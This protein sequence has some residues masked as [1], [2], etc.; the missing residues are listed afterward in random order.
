MI[1][2]K[3]IDLID[4]DSLSSIMKNKFSFDKLDNGD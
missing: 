1:N 3:T 4:I 2:Y